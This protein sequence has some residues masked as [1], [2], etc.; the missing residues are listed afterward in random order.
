MLIR[1]RKGQAF[2]E[3]AIFLGII[4][5]AFMAMQHY[6]RNSVSGKLKAGADYMLKG[7][8]AEGDILSAN[9]YD[10]LSGKEMTSESTTAGGT[11]AMTKEGGVTE[12]FTSESSS[13]AG[14]QTW[15]NTES[16]T[17]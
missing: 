13:Q 4:L 8:A 7:G 12:G 9:L 6:M 14:N 15:K 10:P 17:E 1:T 3:Y 16:P 5:A 11:H 2:S